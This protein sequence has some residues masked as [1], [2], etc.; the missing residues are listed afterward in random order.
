MP[1]AIYASVSIQSTRVLSMSVDPELLKLARRAIAL[2]RDG[3]WEQG[4]P[5]LARLVEGDPLGERLPGET[6]SFYG[7]GIAKL[8][9]NHER[10][11][12]MCEQAIR[13]EFFHADSFLNLARTHLLVDDRL[14][15]H[16]A[17]RRGL[18]MEP[19]HPDLL[20][21]RADMGVRRSPV[22]ASLPRA[23]PINRFLGRAR[24]GLMRV[25]S[26]RARGLAGA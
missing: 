10:G 11:L 6:Y 22:I 16:A 17:I 20:R 26:Q 8:L 7:Y 21:L 23:N 13:L 12:A 9:G 18:K 5:V 15:A 4:F 14:R 2:C 19:K 3:Q 25:A 1:Q 24:H